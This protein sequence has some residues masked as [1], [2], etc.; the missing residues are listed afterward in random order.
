MGQERDEQSALGDEFD[1]IRARVD[2]IRRAAQQRIEAL[3]DPT[4]LDVRLPPRPGSGPSARTDPGPPAGGPS[5]GLRPSDGPIPPRVPDRPAPPSTAPGPATVRP[6]EREEPSAPRPPDVPAPENPPVATPLPTPVAPPDD[7]AAAPGDSLPTPGRTIPVEDLPPPGAGWDVPLAGTT[8]LEDHGGPRS[9]DRTGGRTWSLG[10]R[11]GIERIAS[12]R[13]I[14]VLLWQV[15]SV[16][17]LVAAVVW[18]VWFP[19]AAGTGSQALVVADGRMSPTANR[20]DVVIVAPSPDLPYPLDAVIAFDADGVLVVERVVEELIADTGRVL[21]TRADAVSVGPSRQVDPADVVGSV[22]RVH[23]VV[24]FPALWFDEPGSIL[25]RVLL[26][27]LLVS[28]AVGTASLV[29]RAE[30]RRQDRLLVSAIASGDR[31]PR[32]R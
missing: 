11:E 13:S 31:T 29:V 17:L 6:V 16:V 12:T 2:D 10:L 1:E 30:L 28:S 5:S 23:R 20:G 26:I 24:G 21:V 22:R 3:R 19:L 14:T 4:G 27:L 7:D 32:R 18:A 8:D 15:A 25:W 9:G